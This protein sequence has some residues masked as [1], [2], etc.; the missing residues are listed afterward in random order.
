MTLRV[1]T[2]LV[3]R[4]LIVLVAIGLIT[5]IAPTTNAAPKASGACSKAGAKAKISGLEFKCQK[6][7]GKLI[8]KKQKAKSGSSAS[9]VPQS[10]APKPNPAPVVKIRPNGPQ[11]LAGQT[12][13]D[14]VYKVLN[15]VSKELYERSL[16]V[17]KS[18]S[19]VLSDEPNNK[20]VISTQK[21]VDRTVEMM[22]AIKPDFPD[23]KVYLFREIAWLESNLKPICP[24]LFSNQIQFGWANA[25][26][27][28]LWSG[29]LTKYESPGFTYDPNW[30]AEELLAFSGS[31]ESVHLIQ[32]LSDP[33]GAFKIPAWYREGSANV[34]AGL[35][36]AS[37]TEYGNGDYGWAD[38]VSRNSWAKPRCG[39]PFE[40]WKLKNDAA[41]HE[42][43][44][45]CEYDLGRRLV[46]FIVSKERTFDNVYKVNQD[47][48]AGMGFDEAFLKHH[49]M[50]RMDFLNEVERW[51]EKLEWDK[52]VTY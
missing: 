5:S 46:E 14:K 47:V 31:H 33:D 16:K 23:N 27:G 52:A 42:A 8:W 44:K 32:V 38:D 28:S 10:E 36:M 13:L 19:V 11:T 45:N 20:L 48:R 1:N 12:E 18:Q 2:H 15:E 4:S 22:R 9:G 21:V 25:G 51:L 40:Q 26:C 7:K 30:S 41:G 39:A 43:M 34:G 3:R 49:G 6:V 17:A 35:V 24:S 37:M 50:T 29:S